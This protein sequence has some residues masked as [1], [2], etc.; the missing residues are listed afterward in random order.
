MTSL[1][2]PARFNGPPTSANGG[3]VAGAL[4]AHLR[5]G[6]P[7]APVTVTLHAPPPLDTDLDVVA[8][9]DALTLCDDDVVLARAVVADTV[10]DPVPD[11]PADVAAAARERFLAFDA[12]PFTGCFVCG[13]AR[14]DG[15]HVFTGPQAGDDWSR[16][17]GP[18]DTGGFA[19]APELAWAV[20]DCPSGWAA[21][22]T[23]TPALLASYT[24]RVV[25]TPAAGE[26]L[27][28]VAA[29]DGARGA[30]GRARAARSALYGDD[31]RLLAHAD[32]VWVRP[33]G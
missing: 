14:P 11:V 20:L 19:A 30:S 31:A 22:L 10:S 7:G 21:G 6:D 2:V 16:V 17:A 8:D 15:L 32:A 25:D 33:R 24:V 9:G 29:D 23:E 26:P 3:W 18:V 13:T 28:V 1:R 12:H 5:T 4:A 27:R